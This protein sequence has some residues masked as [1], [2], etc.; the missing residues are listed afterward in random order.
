MIKKGI[1]Y[2]CKRDFSISQGDDNNNPQVYS[3]F[4]GEEYLSPKDN[5]LINR[6]LTPKGNKLIDRFKEIQITPEVADLNF[7]ENQV[8]HPSHYNTDNPIIA[9]TTNDTTEYFPIEC[10]TVIRN[11]SF[12]KGNAIKYLWRAGIKEE[13][14]K[15]NKNKEI[16][17]LQKAIWY[18]NDRINQLKQIQ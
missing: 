9:V 11:M 2:I 17:D 15:S 10:I 13:E 1:K 5:F 3:F 6:Y 7:R 14:G 8:D 18:I 12:W 16:E 4:E